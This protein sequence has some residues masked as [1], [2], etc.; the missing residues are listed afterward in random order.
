MA[1][2][3]VRASIAEFVHLLA[4]RNDADRQRKPRR[5]IPP[6]CFSRTFTRPSISLSWLGAQVLCCQTSP[7]LYARSRSRN[8]RL[9]QRLFESFGSRP[10]YHRAKLFFTLERSTLSLRKEKE[11]TDRAQSSAHGFDRRAVIRFSRLPIAAPFPFSA[12]CG[13]HV[14]P[15]RMSGASAVPTIAPLFKMSAI[16]NSAN[17]RNATF[18]GMTVQH[19]ERAQTRRQ[20]YELSLRESQI[21]REGKRGGLYEQN[22]DYKKNMRK[23]ILFALFNWASMCWWW[24]L[25]E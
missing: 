22:D 25:V 7:S 5:S 19:F 21:E 24:M 12:E 3:T 4:I 6:P 8:R 16:F 17:V 23:K 14:Q 1:I 15:S 9:A 11:R 2:K 10:E 18:Q 13:A 20:G